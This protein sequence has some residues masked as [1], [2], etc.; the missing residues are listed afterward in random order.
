MKVTLTKNIRLFSAQVYVRFQREEERKDI[1]DYLNGK[2]RFE[3]LI[4]NRIKDYLKNIGVFDAQYQLTTFGNAVKDIGKMFVNEEGKYQIWYTQNDAFFGSKI[5]YFKRLQPHKDEMGV[6]KITLDDKGH[7]LL[8]TEDNKYTTMNLVSTEI[9]GKKVPN[10]DQLHFSWVWD[11]LEKSHYYF[12]GQLTQ[13]NRQINIK[14]DAIFCDINLKKTI[15]LLPEWNREQNKYQIRFGGLKDNESKRTFEY[16]DF[17]LSSNWKD[18]KISFQNLPL[19]PYDKEEAKKWR[20]WLLNEALKENYFNP[21]DFEEKVNELNAK[22]ALVTFGLDIPK[23]KDFTTQTT[24]K[25]VFWHLNAPM[26][27]NPNTK[28]KLSAKPVELK[29]NDKISFAEIVNKLSLDNI[30]SNSVFIY[31]DRFVYKTNQQ[32]AVSALS[33]ALNCTKKIVITDLAPKDNISDFIQKNVPEIKLKDHK[34]IFKGMPPHDRYLIV[35]NTNEITIWNVS[36]SIDYISFSDK[37]IDKNTIGTIKQSVVF[38]PISTAMITKD[39]L[40]FIKNETKNGN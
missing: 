34:S 35:S 16:K 20:D 3:P 23:A 6:D 10:N 15:E 2:K 13:Q 1:Q 17:S 12:S 32:K 38:T 33:K 19:M 39:F 28:I 27:L 26:D 36:N 18:F 21:T 4:E 24:S 9:F 40:N 7:F 29:H 14:E 22:E 37:N 25:Q 11:N 31:Y 8:P 30:D 5:F